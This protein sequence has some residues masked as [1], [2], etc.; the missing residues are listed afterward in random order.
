M[1]VNYH[2]IYSPDDG[3]ACVRLEAGDPWKLIRGD[4]NSKAAVFANQQNK[5]WKP[6]M[7][8]TIQDR[9]K[10]HDDEDDTFSRRIRKP[11]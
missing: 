5:F 7:K 3:S 4:G 11:K 10:Y 1:S 8:E 2:Q 9:G 6:W